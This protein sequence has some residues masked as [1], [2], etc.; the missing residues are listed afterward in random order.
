M[1][2]DF[3]QAFAPELERHALPSIRITAT[4]LPTDEPASAAS[5]FRGLPQLP[6]TIPYPTDANGQPLLM[7]A[8]INLAEVPANDF[9]PA[10]GLLQFYVPAQEW[11]NMEDAR[12]LYIGPEH[13]G[14]ET[15]Q[16]FSFLPATHYDESPIYCEHRLTFALVT[17]YG[18]LED[19]RFAV[20]FNG[21]DGYEYEE[22]LPKAQQEVFSNF[23][24]ASGHKL[25]GYAM[26]TQGDPRE[27]DTAPAV[28]L[29]QID[30]DEEIMFGDS[31][32][33]HFFIAEQDLRNREF[34]KAYFYW[35][36]C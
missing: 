18:G 14:A 10:A 24:D 17:E 1:I 13:E 12:V 31:G 35:D 16:D 19:C 3:L 22:T 30:V 28:Q 21:L 34:N 25:G 32:V 11:Y 9:L 8:Q 20:G 7:L 15:Q 36:C 33:A 6:R 5:K 27:V 26:F 23:L 29:L 2:P 4:P